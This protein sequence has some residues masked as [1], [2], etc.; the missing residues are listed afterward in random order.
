MLDL[1]DYRAVEAADQK[2]RMG[3]SINDDELAL[4]VMRYK[5]ACEA[6]SALPDPTYRLVRN[7][8]NRRWQELEGYQA[9]RRGRVRL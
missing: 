9:S 2:Y 1:A 5:A 4:L 6:I 3:D 7:D 8:I